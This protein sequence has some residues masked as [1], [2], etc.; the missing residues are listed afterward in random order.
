M[1]NRG[2][3]IIAAAAC[4][5]ILLL[6]YA[7]TMPPTLT[8]AHNGA[9]GGELV[10][11]VARGT[12]PHPPGFP[13][14]LLLG[15]VF[16]RFPWGTPAWRLNLMSAVLA[17]TAAGL[18]VVAS[19]RLL[20]GMENGGPAV[21]CA[22]CTGLTLGLSPL[23]WSQALIT[24][25]YAPA[26]LFTA[27]VI[28]MTLGKSPTWLLGL[29]WGTGVGAHATLIFLAPIVVWRVLADAGGRQHRFGRLATI[30]IA[31][32]LAWGIL[33]GPVL[34]ARGT[35]PFPWG[36]LNTPAGWWALVSAKLYRGYPFALPLRDWPQRL[37]AWIGL[38]ARQFTP[39]GAVLAGLGVDHLWRTRRPLALASAVSFGAFSLYAVG[40]NT[41]DS[42]VYLTLALPLAA[43]WLAT[44]LLR[45]T[46]WITRRMRHGEWAILLLPL[47]LSLLFWKQMDI[48]DDTNATTWADHVLKGAP[49]RAVLLTE[50][51]AHT[52]ALWYTHDVLGQRPD[53]VVIDRDLWGLAPYRTMMTDVLGLEDSESDLTPEEAAYRTGRSLVS[54]EQLTPEEAP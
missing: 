17:A 30:G 38:L 36:D 44:G 5:V 40:Y 52:F 53:I 7:I 43:L 4:T 28:V 10:A 18:M 47:L 6:I 20:D 51:D 27:L 25:V 22:A 21:L 49:P 19:W 13:T 45:V 24:E 37:L 32:L 12:I 41:T 42:L 2:T 39:I 9:D 35:K 11:A 29:I 54:A 26:A 1:T 8:W 50:R 33:H 31:A 23:F 48:S 34:L 3:V 16:I 14:Y 46:A 15:E